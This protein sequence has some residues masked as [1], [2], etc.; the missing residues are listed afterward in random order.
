MSNHT[1]EFWFRKCGCR[2]S[3][4]YVFLQPRPFY[5]HFTLNRILF[6]CFMNFWKIILGRSF[7]TSTSY[8]I[9]NLAY[10]RVK[11][12]CSYI[13]CKFLEY[14]KQLE[15]ITG[16]STCRRSSS[17]PNSIGISLGRVGWEP[18]F[19]LEKSLNYK[20]YGNHKYWGKWSS[21][22]L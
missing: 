21:F 4:D 15:L 7:K 13:R 10:D 1:S 12:N 8:L 22:Y 2:I 6:S 18:L 20:L 19:A 9:L 5:T 3:L 17:C 16:R 14:R 11:Q